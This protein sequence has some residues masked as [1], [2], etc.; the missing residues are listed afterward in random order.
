MKKYSLECCA[1]RAEY[2]T[3]VFLHKCTRHKNGALLKTVYSQKKLRPKKY[4]GILKFFDWLPLM[5]PIS[6]NRGP[7]VYRSLGLAGELGLKNLYISFSGFWKEKNAL[8]ET[9]TFK[10]F[11][12]VV[13]LAHAKEKGF[14][15]V[16]AP[17]AGNTARALAVASGFVDIDAV[18][19]VPEKNLAEVK[20]PENASLKNFLLIGVKG[21]Y[22]RA[23]ELAKCFEYQTGV[24]NH[25]VRDAL[26][27]IIYEAVLKTKK[28]P[29]HYF[30]A[31][32]SGS[33]A[34]AA[35][36]AGE[37][38]IGDGRFGKKL[39]KIHISQCAEFAPIVEAWH[40]RR[41][42][43]RSKKVPAKICA[44]VLS[45]RDPAYSIKGGLYDALEKTG[46]KA[47]AVNA[48]EVKDAAKIFE[49]TEGADI[50]SAAAVCAASL[51]KAVE[52][53]YVNK[54][55]VI[56]LNITGGGEKRIKMKKPKPIAVVGTKKELREVLNG[57]GREGC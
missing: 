44:K 29:Q 38:L 48:R 14:N 52:K 39:P 1:C 5:K 53:G 49:K 41:K 23:I 25:A 9:C 10:E 30:Q 45:H 15:E 13:A 28:L 50:V 19:L 21:D 16:I 18:A 3:D 11:E 7:A 33:G 47:Y 6:Y 32:S 37:R 26:A 43:I 4:I 17:S 12:G 57:A 54:S 8:V 40:D 20:V 24:R 42:K 35:L 36:E 34:I 56:L 46:G 27:A 22:S 55:D 51:I 31:V 2:G